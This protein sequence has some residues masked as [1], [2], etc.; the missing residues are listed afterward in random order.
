MRLPL[1]FG[2]LLLV[3]VANGQES[4]KE[5]FTP[6]S[7]MT[8][9]WDFAPDPTLPNVLILGDSISIGYTRNVRAELAGKAN[10]FRPMN[11]KNK[12][13]PDNCGD[14]E[15]G[16]DGLERWLAGQ[17]WSVIHCN[18]GLWDVCYRVP[19]KPKTGNRD[20]V[21][22]KIAFTQEQYVANLDKIVTRLQATGAKVIW[23]S[24][25]WIPEE[26]IGRVA[27]DEVRYNAAAAALMEKKKIPVNDLHA[28]TAGWAGKFSKP[29]DVHYN[30]A[31]SALLGKQVAA[32]IASAL[33]LVPA[34]KPAE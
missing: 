5:V 6:P 10:V 8:G 20:K 3:A 23:A 7:D 16:L 18:W 22:G 14:T 34:E 21:N 29:G 11:G 33:D 28:L 15:M 25:T 9:S 26:E 4:K 24:T 13:S 2:L 27:G 19:G 31:G 32:A 12:N 17:K 30:A 1:W